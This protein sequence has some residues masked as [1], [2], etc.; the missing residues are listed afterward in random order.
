MKRTL[1]ALLTL[2][3]MAFAGNALAAGATDL[4]VS[5]T[6]AGTCAFDAPGYTMTF[7][8][9]DQAAATDQ[10]ATATL[11]FTCSTGVNWT[12]DDIAGVRSM[13]G[14]NFGDFL[15]YTISP[16]VTTGTDTGTVTLTGTVYAADYELASGR[17]P[18]DYED[19]VTINIL[20]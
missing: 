11:A 2:A 16:Y 8:V 3:V 10:T 9:L 12:I 1:I 18:D 13:P 7:P 15:P 4:T 17:I 5:A 6:V 14:L 19:V 20:P